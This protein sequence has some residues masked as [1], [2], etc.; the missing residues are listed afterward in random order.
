[1]FPSEITPLG[2]RGGLAVGETV[3]GLYVRSV[4]GGRDEGAVDPVPLEVGRDG[5]AVDPVALV[6]VGD[7]GAVDLV[8]V[9]GVVTGEPDSVGPPEDGVSVGGESAELLA[10]SDEQAVINEAHRIAVKAATRRSR[11]L[12]A[13]RTIGGTGGVHAGR[14]LSLGAGT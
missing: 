14:V 10:A 2:D 6:G 8:A 5:G 9:V 4:E 11:R 3:P 12:W 7:G 1:M 13:R